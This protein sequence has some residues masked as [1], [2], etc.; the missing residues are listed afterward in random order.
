MKK[1]TKGGYWKISWFGDEV[2]SDM[3]EGNPDMGSL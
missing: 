1:K 2:K 3:D